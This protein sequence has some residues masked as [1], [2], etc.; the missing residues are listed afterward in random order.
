M[1]R[2]GSVVMGSAVMI[3]TGRVGIVGSPAPQTHNAFVMCIPMKSMMYIL[4]DKMRAG[5]DFPTFSIPFFNRC[6]V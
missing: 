4:I 2:F 5:I 6:T 1:K 3:L